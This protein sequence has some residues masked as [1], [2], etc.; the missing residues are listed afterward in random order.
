MLLQR[1]RSEMQEKEDTLVDILSIG[2][3]EPG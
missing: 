1:V 2:D 3:A